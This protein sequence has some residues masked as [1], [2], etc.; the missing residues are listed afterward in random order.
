[1]KLPLVGRALGLVGPA[2]DRDTPKVKTIVSAAGLGRNTNMLRSTGL[3]LLEGIP[4]DEAR[5]QA[6]NPHNSKTG[7]SHGNRMRMMEE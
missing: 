6:H 7:Q 3:Y 5:A 4:Q 1:M 2:V